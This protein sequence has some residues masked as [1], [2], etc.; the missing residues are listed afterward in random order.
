MAVAIHRLAELRCLVGKSGTP[1]GERIPAAFDVRLDLGGDR[2]ELRTELI[3]DPTFF[4]IAL[5]N[6]HALN[7]GAMIKAENMAES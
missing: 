3:V 1:F 4:H 7:L 2:F 6:A 5:R